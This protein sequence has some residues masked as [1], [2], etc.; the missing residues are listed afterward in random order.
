MMLWNDIPSNRD[1]NSFE[2]KIKLL[3]SD[4]VLSVAVVVT[5]TVHS[6]DFHDP[7]Y[8]S[9]FLTTVTAPLTAAVTSQELLF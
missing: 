1:M 8:C 3:E 7:K 4:S 2:S 9:I 5:V 6:E